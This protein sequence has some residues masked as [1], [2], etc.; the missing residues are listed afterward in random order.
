MRISQAQKL[1]CFMAATRR[2]SQIKIQISQ[3]FEKLVNS[4]I[5]IRD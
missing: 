2:D 1:K 3:E 5:F 4:I